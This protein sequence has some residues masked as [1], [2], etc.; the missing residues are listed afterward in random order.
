ME[1]LVLKAYVLGPAGFG[2]AADTQQP[3]QGPPHQIPPSSTQFT[4]TLKTSKIWLPILPPQVFRSNARGS[5]SSRGC[6]EGKGVKL[7]RWTRSAAPGCQPRLIT[8]SRSFTHHM[9]PRFLWG[10]LRQLRASTEIL[11]YRKLGRNLR[12][13]FTSNSLKHS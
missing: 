6:A 13:S 11:R 10:E 12:G 4:E 3:S 7:C 9:C 8:R 1:D 5:T 2:V